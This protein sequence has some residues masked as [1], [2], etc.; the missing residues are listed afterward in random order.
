MIAPPVDLTL[1][2]ATV[3]GL[4]ALDLD[5]YQ[6]RIGDQA[7]GV[8]GRLDPDHMDD[9]GALDG[10][11]KNI[12]P[13]WFTDHPDPLTSATFDLTELV[14]KPGQ[15]YFEVRTERRQRLTGPAQGGGCETPLSLDGLRQM[16]DLIDRALGDRT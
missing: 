2:T 11:P 5:A 12:G 16:R 3:T 6:R 13:D 14:G 8:A 4:A 15:F 9:T 1:I 10:L 7:A